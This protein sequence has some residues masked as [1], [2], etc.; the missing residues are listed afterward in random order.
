VGSIL[1]LLTGL[2]G[3]GLAWQHWSDGTAFDSKT[4][5]VFVITVA[6]E[7]AVAGLG[8]GV[9]AARRKND[10]IPAWI[11][12][13]IGVHLFSMAP[14]LSYPLLYVVAALVSMGALAAI[15]TEVMVTRGCS[16][17]C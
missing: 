6:I 11:A 8:A 17:R 4:G 1:S 2:A 7:F 10:I 16:M 15:P 13:V 12:L 3:G 14:L 9:L 5:P